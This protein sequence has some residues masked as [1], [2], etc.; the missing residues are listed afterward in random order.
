MNIEDKKVVLV[1]YTLKNDAGDVL[2]TSDGQDPLAYLHGAGN[3]IPGLEAELKGKKAG[4]KVDAV[5]KPEDGYGTRRDEL[6]QTVPLSNFDQ[7]DQ[8]KVGVQFYVEGPEGV[9]MATVTAMEGDSV[10][11][12]LNHPLADTTLHFAVEIIEVREPTEDE[13]NHGHVHGE[14]CNH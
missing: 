11:V 4:D 9:M 1:H 2:D 7:P 8:V 5:I 6:V 12:D 14:G 10:T 3:I 13:L